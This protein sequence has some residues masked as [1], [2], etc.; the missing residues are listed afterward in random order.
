MSNNKDVKVPEE[1][2]D[3]GRREF[4]KKASYAPP[5]LIVLG[6]LGHA[7][8]AY[9]ADLSAPCGNP[10]IPGCGGPLNGEAPLGALAAPK[11]N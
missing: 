9:G 5:A 11:K 1:G 10:N 6:T 4:L 7:G 3:T 2:I 8:N